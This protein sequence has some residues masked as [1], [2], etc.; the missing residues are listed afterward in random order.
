MIYRETDACAVLYCIYTHVL[1]VFVVVFFSTLISKSIDYGLKNCHA[2]GLKQSP[3]ITW[4]IPQ[5]LITVNET[6]YLKFQIWVI[7]QNALDTESYLVE[8]TTTELFFIL[9]AKNILPLTILY[10]DIEPLI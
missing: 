2:L 3:K 8:R 1:N 9:S 4:T 10:L 7:Y 5:A 6:F